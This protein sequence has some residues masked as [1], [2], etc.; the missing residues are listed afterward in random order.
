MSFIIALTSRL[1]LT[2]SLCYFTKTHAYEIT[3]NTT[4]ILS[5]SSE[6]SYIIV[7]GG[8]AGECSVDYPSLT[9][10]NRLTVNPNISVLV[11]EAGRNLRD[12]PRITD[13]GSFGVADYSD[14]EWDYVSTNQSLGNRSQ[15]LTVGK[16]LGGSSAINGMQWTRG[17]AAQY[18]ALEKLGN[19]GWN[20]DS[21]QK[22]YMKKSERFHKPTLNQTN[23][24]VTF[25]PSAH[26]LNG[27]VS[28]GFPN[29]Y[30][31][32]LCNLWDVLIQASSAVFPGIR[33][34]GEIDQCSG[35]PRGVSRCSYSIIPGSDSDLEAGENIR[36]SS[37]ESYVY[38]LSPNDRPNLH[39]LV[40]HK[41]VNIVWNEHP[42]LPPS[43]RGVAFQAESDPSQSFLAI[44]Q[45][46]VIVSLGALSSAPFLERS[47]VGDRNL[48][49]NLD[50]SVT[51]D[52][53][54][55][56]TN[57]QDQAGIFS[58]FDA[59]FMMNTTNHAP[60]A[61][62]AAFVTLPQILGSKGAEAYV[63]DLKHSLQQRA[64]RIVDTG[65]LT[66]FEGAS[67]VLEIQFEQIGTENAPVVE[68][69]FIALP[70]SSAFAAST[71]I[72]L[73][74]YRGNIHITSNDPR[75][76]PAK[77][78]TLVV[79]A[80]LATRKLFTQPSV[81]NLYSLELLPGLTV[82]TPED[83]TAYVFANYSAVGH[84]IGTV[85]ML[86]QS[87]G[88]AVDAELKV[89]GVKGVRV[90]DASILPIQLSAHLQSTV[91]GIAEKAAEMILNEYEKGRREEM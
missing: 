18:D 32:P 55:V 53:P 91:Y 43:A 24:G 23:L 47:G 1:F 68:L 34:T 61:G 8:T 85:P 35:D 83:F 33:T 80:S 90:A 10:A 20:F 37:A 17:T 11:I 88:G 69:D 63:Q 84:F 19:P 39:I 62:A 6:F 67:K 79:N 41:A 48:L 15:A 89:Y 64:Q 16:V 22:R 50:I 45:K 71:W 56:G 9:I 70:A 38:S 26:G 28:T 65:G 60:A 52:L 3:N 73:P 12:D 27:R 66:S 72:L 25:Q 30:P 14:L 2:W 51:A 82:Q 31:C 21:M 86:P 78:F 7:G 5:K 58:L 76:V 4:S 57:L 44:V 75:I 54:A 40:E 59:S 42:D 46:E 13:P 77:D 36:S 87:L 29:P 81:K 74:Q 49:E